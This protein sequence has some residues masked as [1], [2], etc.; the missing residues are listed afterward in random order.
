MIIKTW[1]R[2]QEKDNKFN[3]IENREKKN[4]SD[5]RERKVRQTRGEKETF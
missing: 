1:R 5:D 4:F 2:L 3:G